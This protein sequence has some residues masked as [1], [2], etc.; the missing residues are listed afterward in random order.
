[1]RF[2]IEKKGEKIR[3]VDDYRRYIIQPEKRVVFILTDFGKI[4]SKY[5]YITQRLETKDDKTND[6]REFNLIIKVTDELEILEQERKM[7]EADYLF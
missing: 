2:L 5:Q 7:H 4:E 3:V 1:M 6:L